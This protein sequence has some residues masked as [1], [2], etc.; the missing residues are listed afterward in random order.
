MSENEKTVCQ[1]PVDLRTYF[2][3][4]KRVLNVE[5]FLY[6][7]NA[8]KGESPYTNYGAFSRFKF[9]YID[10]TKYPAF[11]VE[12]NIK[13]DDIADIVERT[14]YANT[15]IYD[16]ELHLSGSSTESTENASPA[17]TCRFT[18]GKMK[19]KSP[20]EVLSEDPIKGKEM[21][22]QH[23]QFLKSNLEKYPKN[24]IQMDAIAEASKLMSEGKLENV[25]PA[26]STETITILK[27]EMRPLKS[28][29]QKYEYIAEDGK[30]YPK[31]F[32]YEI[33]IM[34]SPSDQYPY[35]I[36][37]ENY[38]A[39]VIEREDKT[40]NVIKSQAQDV[41]PRTFYMTTKDFNGMIHA[42]QTNMNQFEMIIANK[43]F[44][45]AMRWEEYNRKNASANTTNKSA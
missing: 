32:V 35:K 21:L 40:L 23:Y 38:Y 30:K 25:K 2:N 34:C 14:K 33:G 8:D 27:P 22:N 16:Y 28:K 42:I 26:A 13:P 44:S 18:T 5:S 43:Q 4:K 3:T 39:P 31:T 19:G 1:Y 24:K 6:R 36:I 7:A 11:F 10:K 45:D 12:A 29:P 20:A 17:Y 9:T 41:E 15:K 37:I